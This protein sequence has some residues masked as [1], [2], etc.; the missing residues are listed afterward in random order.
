MSDD[1]KWDDE[2]TADI[3]AAMPTEAEVAF[4]EFD[5]TV[6][7][8]REA[9]YAWIARA[10]RTDHEKV[11]VGAPDACFCGGAVRPVRWENRDGVLVSGLWECLIDD[12]HFMEKVEGVP[13]FAVRAPWHPPRMPRN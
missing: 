10:T 13:G 7:A 11:M 6:E 8:I 3:I 4:G 12:E 1:M 2:L 9:V 5:V